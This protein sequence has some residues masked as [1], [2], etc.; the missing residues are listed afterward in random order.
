M[1]GLGEKGKGREGREGVTNSVKTLNI[2]FGAVGWLGAHRQ[3]KV[4]TVY[5]HAV[6]RPSTWR[7]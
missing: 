7:I 1:D 2:C 6:S 5:P 4:K 3:T